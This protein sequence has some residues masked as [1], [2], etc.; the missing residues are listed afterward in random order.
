MF[1]LV[2]DS[3]RPDDADAAPSTC[4]NTPPSLSSSPFY[5]SSMRSEPL[6][7]LA[8]LN[9]RDMSY[10]P[11]NL[12]TLNSSKLILN[13][14]TNSSTE[15]RERS[16]VSRTPRAVAYDDDISDSVEYEE[17]HLICTQ[18]VYVQLVHYK[19]LTPALMKAI[20]STKFSC[21]GDYIVLGYGVRNTVKEVVDHPHKYV[22]CEVLSCLAEGLE[23][24]S[25]FSH[26]ED[27]VNVSLVRMSDMCTYRNTHMA[28]TS[29]DSRISHNTRNRLE[30]KLKN[31]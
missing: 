25:V 30:L 1:E 8:S 4:T 17:C 3:A 26:S 28:M 18:H 5:R 20:V 22:S 14:S 31:V 29:C 9:P 21:T 7:L 2:I 13:S 23:S 27:E 12:N 24:V 16:N 10:R 6:N 11:S 15:L 19:P